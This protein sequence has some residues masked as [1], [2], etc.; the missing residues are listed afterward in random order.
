[1][2]QGV[3][4]GRKGDAVELRVASP[5]T[6]TVVALGGVPDAVFAQEI[7]GP[8]LAIEP[9]PGDGR[10]VAP[11]D[12]RMASLFPHAFAL[13]TPGGR[14]VLVHLGIDTVRLGGTGFTLH[15]AAGDDVTT[16]QEIV[17]WDVQAVA[18]AGCPTV[19]P[20]VALQAEPGSVRPCAAPGDVVRAGDELFL[21]T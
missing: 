19:S 3:A 15:V 9:D 14:T 8:G 11:V 7:V 1:M 20:V 12:G 6:G 17:A 21:W 2:A 4:G 10:V 16:G 5:L 13:E 18:R